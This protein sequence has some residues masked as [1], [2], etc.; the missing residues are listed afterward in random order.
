[1][2]TAL[3][4]MSGSRRSLLSK[5]VLPLPRKPV[6]STGGPLGEN[7]VVWNDEYL[8]TEIGQT[9]TQFDGLGHIGIQLGKPRRHRGGKG[10]HDGCRRGDNGGRYS[11][12][13]GQTE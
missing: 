3:S 2:M 6:I 4:D 7:M 12:R 9:G 5:V 13:T 8:A 1:M 10:P 11:R